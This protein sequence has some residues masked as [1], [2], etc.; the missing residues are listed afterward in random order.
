MSAFHHLNNASPT[1]P[2]PGRDVEKDQG[3]LGSALYIHM[4]DI[5]PLIGPAERVA[6]D[7]RQI[8]TGQFSTH[9]YVFLSKE[10]SNCR[11]LHIPSDSPC[12][13]RGICDSSVVKVPW[14]CCGGAVMQLEWDDVDFSAQPC[15]PSHDEKPYF[16]SSVGL[17]SAEML[18]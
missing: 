14:A 13:A 18:S 4:V 7:R 1:M 3:R 15:T 9:N 8:S 10:F 2:V 5:E 6:V 16:S 12:A 11:L 17:K